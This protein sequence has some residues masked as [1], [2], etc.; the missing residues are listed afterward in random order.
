M[1]SPSILPFAPQ[2]LRE[3]ELQSF[4][5]PTVAVVPD[6]MNQVQFAS[7]M[8]DEACGAIDGDG[9]GS[10]V[11]TTR[12]Q[13]ILLQT[14]NR[15]LV[16]L[17]YKPIVGLTQSAVD[18]IT[19]AA[20]G[21]SASGGTSQPYLT[22]NLQASTINAFGGTVLSGI[23]ACSGRYGYTRQDQSIAYPDLFSF[24]N[25]LNLVTMFG[26][27]APWVAIDIGNTD[28]D[29][30]SGEVWIPAGLQLQKYSE[31]LITYTAGFNP[32]QVPFTLKQVCVALVKNLGAK[33][34]GTT[35]VKGIQLSRAGANITMSD[36]VMDPTLDVML[37][38]FKKVQAY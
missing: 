37:T 35:G 1:S 12:V 34:G 27:P 4:G 28:Y 15:N 25:P 31:I 6:I 32:L 26:G 20:S 22:G 9:N 3:A 7:L 14:R 18:T 16:Q 24:I 2:Y 17:A 11:Y 10:L 23:V 38:P 33:G 8:I 30:K 13:R 21:A 19:A 5:L 29:Y 36:T